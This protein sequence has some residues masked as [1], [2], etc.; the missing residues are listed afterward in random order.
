VLRLE[1]ITL[2]AAFSA[3]AGRLSQS[4]AQVGAA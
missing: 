3:L 4:P 2:T 1:G